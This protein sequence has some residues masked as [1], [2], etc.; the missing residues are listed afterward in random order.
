MPLLR[1]AQEE[2]CPQTALKPERIWQLSDSERRLHH[3]LFLL[4]ELQK[5]KPMATSSFLGAG[6]SMDTGL[7]WFH[8]FISL[9]SPGG[10]AQACQCPPQAA[11]FCTWLRLWQVTH[12]P[13]AVL[14]LAPW[15]RVSVQH[16][17][18]IAVFCPF[19]LLP[20]PPLFTLAPW[21]RCPDVHPR[22]HWH[23]WAVTRFPLGWAHPSADSHL[24]W[25]ACTSAWP[26]SSCPVVWVTRQPWHIFTHTRA[27]LWALSTPQATFPAGTPS[28][29]L[30][31]FLAPPVFSAHPL[32]TARPLTVPTRPRTSSRMSPAPSPTSSSS[33]VLA[34]PGACLTGVISR[35]WHFLFHCICLSPASWLS[36]SPLWGQ[37]ELYLIRSSPLPPPPTCCLYK[38]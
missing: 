16:L 26:G 38:T 14:W 21:L 1:V 19:P 28:R 12:M 29:H 11:G 30:L 22:P 36:P 31:P 2:E 35:L 33:V 4:H 27:C 25:S 8:S 9:S 7:G 6:N 20:R 13:A 17:W 24:H 18:H 23:I 34:V 32:Q 10:A 3:C 15:P 37:L 5:A